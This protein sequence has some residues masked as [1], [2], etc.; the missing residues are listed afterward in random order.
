[1]ASPSKT[2]SS[3]IPAAPC[4]LMRS[5]NYRDTEDARPEFSAGVQDDDAGWND[6]CARKLEHELALEYA[7]L[8]GG[9]SEHNADLDD[10]ERDYSPLAPFSPRNR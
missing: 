5:V 2:T 3:A 7:L 10:L 6:F 9:D 4:K 1:M 8:C